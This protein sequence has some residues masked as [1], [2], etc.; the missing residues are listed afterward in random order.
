[1]LY[2]IDISHWQK[3]LDLSKIFAD[4]V[5]VKATEGINFVDSQCDNFYQ[6]A[7][8]LGKLLGFYHF[9][10]PQNDAVK[11]A[12][13]FY[14]NTK[15][16]FGEAIPFL[17]WEAENLWDVQW[18]KRFLDEI[19]RLTGI[20]PL[21]YTSTYVTKAYNWTPVVDSG[22]RLWVAQYRDMK[23][24]YN[25]DMSNAG[26]KPT[27]KYWKSPTLWQWTSM[28]RL[29]GYSSNLDCDVFYGNKSG[30]QALVGKVSDN[31]FN[32]T[33]DDDGM[34]VVEKKKTPEEI[35]DDIIAGTNG[36]K[37][38]YGEERYTKL[39]TLG[40]DPKEVQSIVNQKINAKR[41]SSSYY[42]VKYG[43]TLTSIAKKY[44][45]TVAKLVSLNNIK[46]PNIIKIGQKIRVK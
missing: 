7:K 1:M 32:I 6:Q 2:G 35:A 41:A 30:W 43:D 26:S 42:T 19:Y 8:S 3:G 46:N 20:K 15:N 23:P 18:V 38:V 24:D 22:Y 37:G 13:F 5:I 33:T 36:W 40:Y 11:E 39:S 28:G 9:A 17:D 16:Y 21:L 4:F 27:V 25:Y 31:N 34:L 12:N 29:D 14:E 10:R 44:K 45:T